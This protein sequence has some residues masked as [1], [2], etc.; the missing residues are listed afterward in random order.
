VRRRGGIQS[1]VPTTRPPRGKSI[2]STI[3]E[4][5]TMDRPWLASYPP[6]VAA[7]VDVHQF[8]SIR[9]IFAQSCSRFARSPAFTNM[10]RTITYAELD[11]LSRDF[12]AWLHRGAGSSPA[13]GSPS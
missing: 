13:R 1:I 12:G 8:A 7:D 3:V 4:R 9:D 11:R 5:R 2:M 6:G 10:G